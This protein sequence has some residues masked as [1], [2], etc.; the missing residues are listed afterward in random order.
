MNMEL[1]Q[2]HPL[3][4]KLFPL[5]TCA[6]TLVFC[7]WMGLKLWSILPSA[8]VWFGTVLSLQIYY[9]ERG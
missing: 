6:G 7:A 9:S 2:K 5:L 8:G 4:F 1:W 3:A